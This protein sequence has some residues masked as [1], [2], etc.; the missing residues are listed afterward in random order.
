VSDLPIWAIGVCLLAD[1]PQKA[2]RKELTMAER[3]RRAIEAAVYN[4]V[5]LRSYYAG[6]IPCLDFPANPCYSNQC[7]SKK[8]THIIHT[9]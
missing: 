4:A 1:W 6:S 7:E 5:W 2:R 9:I 3:G 8:Q